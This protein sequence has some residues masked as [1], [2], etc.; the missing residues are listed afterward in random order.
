MARRAVLG[1]VIA[2]AVAVGGSL[3]GFLMLH[4]PASG[5]APSTDV[6]VA[7]AV[8]KRTTLSSSTQLSGTLGHGFATPVFGGAPG[9]IVTA[10]P[11]PGTIEQR[12]SALF[13]VDGSP[14]TL[15]YGA[16]PAWRDFQPGMTAGPDVVQL[17]R[18][19]VALGYAAGLDLTVDDSFTAVTDEAVVRWQRATGQAPTGAVALGSVVFEPS[20]VRIAST[21]AALGSLVQPGNPVITVDA[22]SVGVIAQVSTSQT[23]LVHRGDAVSI[24]LPSGSAL[25]GHVAAVSRVAVANTDTSGSGGP[26]P[27]NGGRADVTLPVSVA[28]DDPSAAAALDEAPVTVNVTDKTVRNVLAVPITALVALAEGG[29][30]VY[31]VHGSDRQLIA[32]TPGLFASTLVQVTSAGLHEGDA[33]EVPAS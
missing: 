9:G 4:G 29:Y 1:I 32:V 18:N 17:E 25:N 5:S 14:V 12:G 19:L 23:Y 30:A 15:F 11:V 16:R 33:V 3:A 22:S 8:V 24:T 26:Q 7:T 2:A 31:V 10:L 27:S 6:P 13:E 20:G 28:L 21:E